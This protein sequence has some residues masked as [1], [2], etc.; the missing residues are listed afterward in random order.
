LDTDGGGSIDSLEKDAA[1]YALGFQPS[2]SQVRQ[3]PQAAARHSP[4]AGAAPSCGLGGSAADLL[5]DASQTITLL[6]F[7][8]LMKGEHVMRDPV[9]AIWAAFTELSGGGDAGGGG[10]PDPGAVTV[11]A[12]RRACIKYDVKLSEDELQQLIDDLDADGDGSVDRAEFMRLMRQA[13]WF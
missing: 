2:A 9:E 3:A 12:L 1:M 4:P 10:G 13:P 6:E 8:T 5:A 11:D 7:T